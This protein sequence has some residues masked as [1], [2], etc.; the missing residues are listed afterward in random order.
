[1]IS[2]ILLIDDDYATNEYHKIIINSTNICEDLFVYQYADEALKWLKSI[3][4]KEF[5]DLIFLD[6]NMPRMNGFEFLD[7]Y[8]KEFADSSTSV[9]VMLTT[10]INPNDK[11][12]SK[13]Y[14]IENFVNKPLTVELLRAMDDKLTKSQPVDKKSEN[15]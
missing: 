2:R 15:L 3:D 7:E 10:S 9:I 13:I 6:I 1:M 12:K 5:P 8:E 11:E 14:N 4:K